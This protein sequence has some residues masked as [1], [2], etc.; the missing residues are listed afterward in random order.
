MY[1][2]TYII[3]INIYIYVYI[4]IY[5]CK[6]LKM[7]P[8]NMLLENIYRIKTIV[9]SELQVSIFFSEDLSM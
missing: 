8:F 9:Y 6:F 1:I 7:L 3:Y 2:Y 4:Y 5:I